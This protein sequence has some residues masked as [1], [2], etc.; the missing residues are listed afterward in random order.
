MILQLN[1][2]IP[3]LT[4]LGPG[5]AILII[6]YSEEHYI[7]FV[8]ILDETGEVWTFPNTKVRGFKNWTMGR[9]EPSP[10]EKKEVK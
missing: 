1:P 2:Q 9:K 4:E 3:L 7:E 5:Q 10:F 8:V 6:H